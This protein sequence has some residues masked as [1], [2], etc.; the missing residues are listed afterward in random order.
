M[1]ASCRRAKREIEDMP[2]C[3]IRALRQ[4]GLHRELVRRVPES[5]LRAVAE[6]F[7]AMPS[8]AERLQPEHFVFLK[9]YGRV[10]GKQ[11]FTEN[12]ISKYSSHRW[13]QYDPSRQMSRYFALRDEVGLS[14]SDRVLDYG[15]AVGFFLEAFLR[16]GHEA[17][18]MEE[19]ANTLL[20][21]YRATSG[22][23]RYGL[24]HHMH[25][26]DS[27][28]IT[29]TWSW[30][31]M[32]WSTYHRLF[33]VFI[34]KQLRRLG[35]RIVVTVPLAAYDGGPYLNADDECDVTHIVRKDREWWLGFLGQPFCEKPE[36]CVALKMAGQ[37][38]TLCAI[39]GNLRLRGKC[40]D[41]YRAT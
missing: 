30:P 29:S 26:N 10:F 20:G 38:G 31:R 2:E 34:W 36:L 19:S 6:A 13:D 27:R 23:G 28:I 4:L 1:R 24:V 7:L 5:I 16:Q 22:C 8:S 40:H 41:L 33:W 3:C 32:C 39:V 15:C 35:Q 18:G 12:V 17:W 21:P 14:A 9:A 11:Y 25:S 37:N